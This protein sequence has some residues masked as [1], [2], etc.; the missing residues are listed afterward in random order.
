[1]FS[2]YLFFRTPFTPVQ[3]FGTALVF[4]GI[5]FIAWGAR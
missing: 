2:A 3:W 5:L 1:V 4:G